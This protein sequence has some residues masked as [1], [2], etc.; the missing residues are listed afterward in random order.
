MQWFFEIMSE[1]LQAKIEISSTL[2]DTG[3]SQ[4]YT[5]LLARLIEESPTTF[6]QKNK[7]ELEPQEFHGLIL[8]AVA[9]SYAAEWPHDFKL[10]AHEMLTLLIDEVKADYLQQM[11]PTHDDEDSDDLFD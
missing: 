3:Q 8:A 5:Q 11:L 9:R 7:I 1:D 6:W 4:V 10:P 2:P